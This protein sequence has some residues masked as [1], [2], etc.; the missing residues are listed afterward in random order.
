MLVSLLQ[1]N[2]VWSRLLG[3]NLIATHLPDDAFVWKRIGFAA[4]LLELRH[5]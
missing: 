4:S 3:L 1:S 5:L 2:S